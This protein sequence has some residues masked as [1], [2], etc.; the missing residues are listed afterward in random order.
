MS[1]P[2][3]TTKRRAV[4]MVREN[5]NALIEQLER[6]AKGWDR[7]FY[8]DDDTLQLWTIRQSIDLH[9]SESFALSAQFA[10]RS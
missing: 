7:G 5:A 8:R 10:S 6:R 4:A 1:L 9:V 3:V 2:T